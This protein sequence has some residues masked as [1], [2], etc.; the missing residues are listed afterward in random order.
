[1][2]LIISHRNSPS[3]SFFLVIGLLISIV[4]QCTYNLAAD[5]RSTC[6]R[7]VSVA[8]LTVCQYRLT[9]VVTL[10]LYLFSK[11]QST[12]TECTS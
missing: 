4:K 8:I 1:M 7:F 5:A 9:K 12:L 10:K 3:L 11:Y 2:E 6:S